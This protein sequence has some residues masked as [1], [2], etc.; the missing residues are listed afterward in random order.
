LYSYCLKL[1]C[2]PQKR[3]PL[4]WSNDAI[5]TPSNAICAEKRVEREVHFEENIPGA[6][7]TSARVNEA[8]ASSGDMEVS[9]RC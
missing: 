3:T 6:K 7:G 8:V 2:H 1:D 5:D 9:S 4:P